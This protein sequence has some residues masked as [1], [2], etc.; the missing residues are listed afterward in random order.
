[1]NNKL[2]VTLVIIALAL[3]LFFSFIFALKSWGAAEAG[4]QVFSGLIDFLT[5]LLAAVIFAIFLSSRLMMSTL[6]NPSGMIA[7]VEPSVLLTGKTKL[8]TGRKLTML[9]RLTAAFLV[10]LLS[11]SLLAQGILYALDKLEMTHALSFSDQAYKAVQFYIY[12]TLFLMLL[13]VISAAS[14]SV[15]NV[16]DSYAVS[17]WLFFP[18]TILAS[19]L[20]IGGNLI[21]GGGTGFGDVEQFR[22]ATGFSGGSTGLVVIT[23]MLVGLTICAGVALY[24]SLIWRLARL[25]ARFGKQR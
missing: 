19:V 8:I 16:L 7:T 23:Q 13:P 21:L 4:P 22:R 25:F 17:Y 12:G 3:L 1:M 18:S 24:E 2:F 5:S 14:F 15:A 10:A 6:P 11:I 20:W 9:C